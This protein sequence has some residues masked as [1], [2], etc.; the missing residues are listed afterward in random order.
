MQI[1]VSILSI[2]PDKRLNYREG[3]NANVFVT[4]VDHWC[5]ELFQISL[6]SGR[7]RMVKVGHEIQERNLRLCEE[8]RRGKTREEDSLS[9]GSTFSQQTRLREAPMILN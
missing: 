9:R 4:V 6:H 1:T 5:L 8:R 7:D 2:Y 3:A